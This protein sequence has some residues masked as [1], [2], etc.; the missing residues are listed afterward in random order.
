M[1]L[2]SDRVL[3]KADIGGVLLDSPRRRGS[4]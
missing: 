1:K 4:P 3:H 2:V